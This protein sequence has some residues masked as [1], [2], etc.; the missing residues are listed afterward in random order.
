[1]DSRFQYEATDCCVLTSHI[2]GK[3]NLHFQH[4]PEAH[5]TVTLLLLWPLVI[6]SAVLAPIMTSLDSIYNGYRMVIIR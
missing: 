2:R 1:M 3:S 5:H 4:I 6:L